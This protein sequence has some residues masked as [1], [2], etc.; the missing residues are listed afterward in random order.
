M[1]NQLRS[2]LRM[3]LGTP[4]RGLERRCQRRHPVSL[5]AFLYP[6]DLYRELIIQHVSGK[7]LVA[8]VDVAVDAGQLVHLTLDG[9]AYHSATVK[10]TLGN[11]IVLELHADM[12]GLRSQ[13]SGEMLQAS[14]NLH[15][16]AR[17]YTSEEACTG[18][19]VNV[20]RTGLGVES[21]LEM[22][23]GQHVLV[24]IGNRPLLSG[25][26]RWSHGGKAGIMTI[27]NVPVLE[28]AY[29]EGTDFKQ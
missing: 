11:R 20:S 2:K 14:R 23:P 29:S 27:V 13:G 21:A 6:L 8:D 18:R 22:L 17:L 24:S 28:L 5:G 12:D 19:V 4:P 26:I 25:K 7:T 15:I 3:P 1:I 16:P 10:G 9:K